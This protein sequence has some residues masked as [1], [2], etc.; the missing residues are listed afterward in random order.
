MGVRATV[1]RVRVTAPSAYAASEEIRIS[2]FEWMADYP[3]SLASDTHEGMNERIG[4]CFFNY[5]VKKTA[6]AFRLLKD[7]TLC[8]EYRKEWLVKQK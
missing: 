6:E 7:D 5:T 8:E 1:R 3:S 2:P 4:K